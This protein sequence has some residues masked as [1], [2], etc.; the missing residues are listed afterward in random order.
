MR[1][2]NAKVIIMIDVI[3]LTIIKLNKTY[4]PLLNELATQY[5]KLKKQME[6]NKQSNEYRVA[7]AKILEDAKITIGGFGKLMQ[8]VLDSIQEANQYKRTSQTSQTS[9][10]HKSE[11]IEYLTKN[12]IGIPILA[13]A[14]ADLNGIMSTQKYEWMDETIQTYLYQKL[15]DMSKFLN[16]GMW[17]PLLAPMRVSSNEI[18]SDAIAINGIGNMEWEGSDIK[19]SFFA[20]LCVTTALIMFLNSLGAFNLGMNLGRE[21]SYINSLI[22]EDLDDLFFGI[23]NQQVHSLSSSQTDRIEHTYPVEQKIEMI[24]ASNDTYKEKFD[25][26]FNLEGVSLDQGINAIIHSDATSYVNIFNYIL[27]M[28]QLQQFEKMEYIISSGIATY[29]EMFSFIVSMKDLNIEEKIWY[30]LLI[31]NDSFE[32]VFNDLFTIEGA[33]RDQVIQSVIQADIVS[34]D[35]L[36]AAI[37]KIDGLTKEELISYLISYQ[38]SYNSIT[39]EDLIQYVLNLNIFTQSEKIDCIWTLLNKYPLNAR[40]KT[41]LDFYNMTYEDF[42]D[43]YKLKNNLTK[44]QS[45]VWDI[46]QRVN[47]EKEQYILE[48]YNFDS[49]DQLDVVVSVC[50][51]EGA[52]S[53]WDLYWVANTIFNRITNSGYVKKY[54]TNPYDQVIAP[55][56]FTVYEDG[57]YLPYLCLRNSWYEQK[58]EL[59]RQAFYDMFYVGYNGI[60]H[61]YIEFRGWRI[62]TFSDTYI[63]SGGNRYGN[64]M[65]EENRIQDDNLYKEVDDTDYE[66]VKRLTLQ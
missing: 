62:D 34:F 15:E 61:N 49:K 7:F 52:R 22:M 19:S 53:Y 26:I 46:V 10:F 6:N 27:S 9:S 42:L 30:A 33:T 24:L 59:A 44:E 3:I 14:G 58:F 64:E 13:C 65:K 20:T 16:D 60:A 63:V 48:H 5:V 41:I 1:K 4:R 11:N 31:P 54:G 55:E 40:V 47:A 23:T 39:D 37:I 17:S 57:F 8:E 21:S 18:I 25:R 43:L 56:Q 45:I 36:F 2:N 29:E 51:A 66:W 32:V 28:D 50:S 12:E 38:A 35:S